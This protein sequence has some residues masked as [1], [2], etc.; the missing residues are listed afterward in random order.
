[1]TRILGVIDSNGSVLIARAYGAPAPEALRTLVLLMSSSSS[2]AQHNGFDLCRLH[3]EDCK[4][5]FQRC[6]Q[7][8]SHARYSKLGLSSGSSRHQR[9][10]A[11]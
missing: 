9:S 3:S 5:V 8:E 6:A 7:H 4:V 10:V 2:Y 11:C 1:M